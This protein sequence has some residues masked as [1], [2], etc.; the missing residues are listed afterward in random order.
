[1]MGMT[2]HR[3]KN[4]DVIERYYV[5]PAWVAH[6]YG[7]TV[8]AVHRAIA[9]GRLTAY[10]VRGPAQGYSGWVLDV[11][12]LPAEWPRGRREERVAV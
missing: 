4:K 5:T 10:R 11:R 1:M 6:H 3:L 9:G 7:V 8:L 2:S 12:L